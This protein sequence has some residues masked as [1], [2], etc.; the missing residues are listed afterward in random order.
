MYNYL[1]FTSVNGVNLFFKYLKEI[2]FDIRKIS[3]EF[4]AI[5]PATAQAIRAVGIN[6]LIIAKQ[7]VS[8][9]FLIE[10]KT[11]VK[12]GDRILIPSAQNGREYLGEGL[13]KLECCV[14]EVPIYSIEEGTSSK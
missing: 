7:F 11:H 1:V 14:D 10:M 5:G 12:P 8:E 2:R 6:P 4:C 9:S 13:R 3:G